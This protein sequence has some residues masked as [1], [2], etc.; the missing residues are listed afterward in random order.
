[1]WQHVVESRGEDLRLA[2][3][4]LTRARHQAVV[5]W[6]PT[7]DSRD[8]ALC[9]LLFFAD[10][11]GNVSPTG[12][13]VPTDDEAVERF[14]ELAERAPGCI[15]IERV[16]GGHGA[17][18]VPEER[19]AVE[20]SASRF[21]RTLD[22]RWRRTSYSGITSAAHEARV[23]SEAEEPGVSDEVLP[24]SS[25]GGPVPLDQ[26]P[27]EDGLRAVP[28]LLAAM[29]GGA[30]VGTVVHG[31]LEDA[32]FAAADLDGELMAALGRAGGPR[33][34]D[35]GDRA[36]VVAG[37]AAAIE[38]PLG[39][40]VGDVRLR[41]IGRSDRV[42]ELGFELP[43]VGGDTPM[44]DLAVDHIGLLL[45]EHLPAGDPLSGYARHL[46]D[47]ALQTGLRG[48]LSG[49]LDV[50]L[51][52]AHHRYAVVDYKTN[53][54]GAD[55]E[56]LSAWHYRPAALAEAMYRAH[57]PL[58]ALLYTVALHRYLRWRLPGYSPERNLAGV[59][60]LFVRG[61]V[62]ASTPR[63]HG[64]PCGVFGWRPPAALVEALSDLLDRG[65][66][67]A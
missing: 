41:D 49:S 2:Y 12:S 4:A 14:T 23:A 42:D 60:Y 54:L 13:R 26:E 10:E 50:V 28:S 59:L 64:Q 27:D 38:T 65:K 17:E 29:P 51:R 15:S 66:V 8:S 56:P 58:Q 20:L 24:D 30:D 37:L 25:A 63:V 33:M 39:P 67:A 7:W 53:W 62:G 3:V 19:E 57:Y 5:W 9:R 46:R 22:P 55:G 40:V 16:S 21:D 1:G 36:H 45:G 6:A 32:D 44:G 11:D 43:L 31:V 18:W 61:M 48:Y 52:V 35:V 34:V 47:P